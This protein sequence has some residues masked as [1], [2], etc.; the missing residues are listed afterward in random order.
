MHAL[1][2]PHT[3]GD[4]GVY[5]CLCWCWYSRPFVVIPC[6]RV[7]SRK[8]HAVDTATKTFPIIPF[9]SLVWQLALVLV[10]GLALV[11]VRGLALVLV[12]VAWRSHITPLPP[13]QGGP[14]LPIHWLP[15]VSNLLT[16]WVERG[17][18]RVCGRGVAS[19]SL[20]PVDRVG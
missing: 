13:R 14:V 12:A 16:G 5:W 15:K 17:V 1:D 10:R 20:Q 11:L 7:Q 4:D 6:P 3:E 19:E 2:S 9:W 18:E 8:G